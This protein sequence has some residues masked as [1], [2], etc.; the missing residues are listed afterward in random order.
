M[1]Q[2]IDT[3]ADT[4]LSPQE[5]LAKAKACE[6]RAEESFQRCDT[7]GFLSQWAS[8][9]TAQLHRRQAAIA[10][11]GGKAWFRCVVDADGNLVP[12]KHIR[13][14]YGSKIAVFATLE[15]AQGRG[16]QV[17]KWISE[18]ERAL[19]KHGL[20][21]GQFQADAQAYMDG[22]GTGLSGT[23]WVATRRVGGWDPRLGSLTEQEEGVPVVPAP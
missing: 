4:T 21:W 2:K 13:T 1:S 16:G 17:V 5:H 11:A 9:M 3:G 19:A 10:E 8:G 7:D 20:R 12:A 23:A 6:E 22:Q 14:R 18:T 15:D